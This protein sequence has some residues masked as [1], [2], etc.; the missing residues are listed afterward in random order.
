[1]KTVIDVSIPMITFGL[2]MAVGS[3]LR[4][5]DFRRLLG[6]PGILLAGLLLPILVL[7]ALAFGLLS[8]YRPSD[9]VAMGMLLVAACPI[10]GLSNFYSHLARASAALSVTLTGLSCLLA[11]FTIPLLGAWFERVLDRPLG[12]AAPV[13]LLTIQILLMLALPVA[14]G[15][16]ARRYRPRVVDRYRASVRRCSVVALTILLALIVLSNPARF[17]RELPET[18][19]LAAVFVVLSFAAGWGIGLLVRADSRDCFTLASEFA[20]RNV[21]VAA[22]L[23]ITLLHRIE[24]TTFAATYVLTEAPLLL[25]AAAAFRHRAPAVPAAA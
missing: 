23:A 10:G 9:A 14:V 16:L 2:L 20:T 15:M 21:A 4:S 6:R 3:D 13:P 17:L 18:V 12:L 7:P 11:I 19:P 22:T 1:M 8:I 24:F 25:L 5:A